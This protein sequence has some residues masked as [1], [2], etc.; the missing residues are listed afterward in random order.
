M[1]NTVTQNTVTQN[2]VFDHRVHT[3]LWKHGLATHNSDIGLLFFLSVRP[4]V[5]AW[6]FYSQ[7]MRYPCSI[8]FSIL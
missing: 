6:H 1:L 8:F 3:Q 2:T 4:S 7:A 5:A